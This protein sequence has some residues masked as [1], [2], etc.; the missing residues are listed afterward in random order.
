MRCARYMLLVVALASIGPARAQSNIDSTNRFGWAENVGWTNW[1]D[2]DG[3]NAGVVVGSSVLSGFIWS[4][5]T[6]WINVGDGTPSDGF[7]YANIDG[8]DFGVN[9]DA[10]GRLHG[11][12]WGE[13]IGWINFD[14]G[15]MADPPQPARVACAD[16]PSGPLSRLSGYVWGENVGWFNLNDVT[17]FVAVDEV[18]TPLK[19]DLNHDGSVNGLDVQFF[20]E[21]L[22][23][24]S[25]PD[26]RD[27]CS[28]DVEATPDG[29]I[30]MDD[31][32]S[33]VTCL[34]G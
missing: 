32:E 9:I 16:P 15:A 26:W 31:V 33:F 17:H 1:R 34:L 28:G 7:Q 4:E 11:M 29:F 23:L 3:V 13:N 5:N 14:G 25:E 2:A 27:V 18:T 6:G 12:A 10:D 19:C 30:D 20:T 8:T 21:F 22:L 24:G